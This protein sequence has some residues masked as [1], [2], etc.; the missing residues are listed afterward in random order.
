LADQPRPTN[1][2]MIFGIVAGVALIFELA[3]LAS[4]G[5]PGGLL[6]LGLTLFL[7]GAGAAIAGRAR[8]AFIASRKVG[9]VVA[10]VGLIGLVAGTVTAPPT[11]PTSASSEQP[12][13]RPTTTAPSAAP[14]ASDDAALAAAEAALAEQETSERAQRVDALVDATTGLLSDSATADA[15]ATAGRTTALAALAAVEVKGRAPRTGYD[16]D[17]FGSGWQDTDRNGCDTRND[18]LARDLRGETFKPGTRN[19]VVLTGSLAD[20]Y[21]GTTMPFLRGQAT[22]GDIQID[23]VVA[24]SDAWQKGAQSWPAGR[25]AAFANDPLNLLA[26]DGG[27]NMGKGDGDAATWLPPNRAYRCAYVARQVAVKMSYGLWM[28]QA[29]KNAIAT[30]LSSCPGEPLPGG[31]VASLPAPKPAPAPAPAP[32][33]APAPA[34]APVPAPPPPPPAPAPTATYYKNCS[35]ARAAGAAPVHRGDPGYGSHLDRDG[36]GIGCE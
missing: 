25:R 18:V 28:T 34:P 13:P 7:I 3:G 36:D 5:L 9:G 22:S 24:L 8:W 19:C 26:V 27:L 31:V 4:L 6:M 21:S 32:K 10:A 30:V 15:V 12:A 17:L 23:H 1:R 2:W 16:R 35:A 11:A 20:P 33:P 29:E 14:T